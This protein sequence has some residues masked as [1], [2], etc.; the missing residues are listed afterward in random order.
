MENKGGDCS[1][2]LTS[3]FDDSKKAKIFNHVN[4]MDSGSLF[5]VSECKLVVVKCSKSSIKIDIKNTQ[6]IFDV[7]KCTL[8]GELDKDS[9]H[10]EKQENEK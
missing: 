5:L 8:T 2:A 6:S 7:N 1:F 3:E 10:I 4:S 9:Y